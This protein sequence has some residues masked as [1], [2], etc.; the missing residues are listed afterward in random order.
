M[1][2]ETLR[3]DDPMWAYLVFPGVAMSLGWAF[4]GFIGGG[5]LG[6]MIPG[7]MVALALCWLLGRWSGVGVGMIAAFGAVGVGFGGQMTY[8]QTVGLASDLSTVCWGVLGL[9]LKGGIWGFSG[10]AVLGL[11][12][13]ISR[14]RPG[15][16]LLGLGMMVAGTWLGWYTVNAPK[17]IY[18]S[19]R[20]DR[21]REEMWAGLL[22]GALGLLLCCAVSPVNRTMWRFALYGL[23]GGWF[24]FGLGGVLI[25]AGRNSSLD[26]AFW[27]WWKGMEYTFGLL[28]GVSLG[29][30]LWR[31]RETLREI[32]GFAA[33]R[34]QARLSGAGGLL[35]LVL[36]GF[37][38]AGFNFE[39]VSFSRFDYTI[40]G[41]ALLGLALYHEVV[42][43]HIAITMTNL[44]FLFDLGE[45]AAMQWKVMSLET[46]MVAAVL[47]TIPVWWLVEQVRKNGARAVPD[48]F[49]L[50]LWA[51]FAVTTA[52]TAGSTFLLG[53]QPVE[54]AL[55]VAMAL[56]LWWLTAWM[57]DHWNGAGA[58]VLPER[59]PHA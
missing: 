13:T 33:I 23:L 10:G 39:Y 58:L 20:L 30:A 41:A 8:G 17:L 9:A 2:N 52:K 11:A 29:Y 50:I 6:A 21:P 12:F 51:A 16:T 49:H 59:P 1:K 42:A 45:A 36:L 7:A 35:M 32:A 53:H 37:L 14:C 34:P 19:N 5:P 40:A 18:F 3:R 56:L 4:R 26:P 24:G 43:W 28:F 57:R 38:T 55:F 15:R 48:G 25:S 31:E 54:Y 27:P 44:A 46:S 47:L 22:L